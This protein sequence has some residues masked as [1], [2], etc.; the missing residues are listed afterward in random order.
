ME[1]LLFSLEF[2]NNQWLLTGAGLNLEGP[3]LDILLDDLVTELTSDKTL[4]IE[5]SVGGVSSSLVLGSITDKTLFFGEGNVGGGSVDTLIISDDFD[6][7]V[8]EHTDAGVGG[9]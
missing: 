5:D 9:S 4:S 8:L 2:D 7:V 3:E 1:L 6:L